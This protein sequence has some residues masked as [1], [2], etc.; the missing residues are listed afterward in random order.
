I[1]V[2][3]A[4]MLRNRSIDGTFTGERMPS[5]RGPVDN[6]FDILGAMGRWLLPGV[7][8]GAK[9][10]WA[11]V[12]VV[13]LLIAAWLGWRVLT[14][15]AKG[16]QF[17]TPLRRF[18]TWLG[19][20]SGLLAV[21]AF[22]YLAY[23]LYVRSTTALNQ[24]ELRLLN[25]AYFSLIVLALLLISQLGRIDGPAGARWH[26]RGLVVAYI[27]AAA[28]VAVGLYA[29]VNFA[30]GDP[31]FN[32][33]YESDTFVEVRANPALDSLP[34]GC[35]VYSNLPNA[36]YP[37]LGSQWSP[38]E[39]GLESNERVDDLAELVESLDEQAACLVWV[40]EPPEYGHLWSRD[41]LADTLELVSIAE[42]DSVTV[43]ALELRTG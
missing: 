23:M 6:A 42:N 34:E 27:W 31:F 40:D 3:V 15:G 10:L 26:S 36:L 35:E 21:Q 39:T 4:W 43:Y 29:A 7:A 9:Y 16:S 8:D 12:G 24:L 20:P 19:R 41:E 11:A 5:A 37:A 18:F 38:R 13:V 2:P 14:S 17:D 1:V 32:G 33:N 30:A 22:G 25:P 28:N